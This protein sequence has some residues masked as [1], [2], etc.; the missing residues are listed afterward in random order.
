[1]SELFVNPV[2]GEIRFRQ[3]AAAREERTPEALLQIAVNCGIQEELQQAV[4]QNDIAYQIDFLEGRIRR[5]QGNYVFYG[6]VSN[7]EADEDPIEGLVVGNE[8][9]QGSDL[10]EFAAEHPEKC[11]MYLSWLG[12]DGEF[13][14]VPNDG[15]LPEE[16]FLEE[17]NNQIILDLFR[18]GGIRTIRDLARFLNRCRRSSTE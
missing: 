12:E 2:T 14:V 6:T 16:Q 11:V 15:E 1:M 17:V 7:A 8:A 13:V 10:L 18:A 9:Q 5:E 4:L 3:S